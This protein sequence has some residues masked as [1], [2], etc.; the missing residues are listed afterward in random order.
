MALLNTLLSKITG[1]DYSSNESLIREYIDKYPLYM[2]FS[3]VIFAPAIEELLFRKSIKNIFK[4]KY[5]FIIISG[6]LFGISHVTNFRD[7]NELLFSIPYIIMGID[8]AYI[9]HK[10][11]NIFTTMTFH[12]GH[13]LILLIIRFII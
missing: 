5:L 11:N 1:Q 12:L 9:Y 2:F 10:T 6:I 8:F 13:N 7:I 3:S 4:N